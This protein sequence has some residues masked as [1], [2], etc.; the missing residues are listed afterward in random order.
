[1]DEVHIAQV[2]EQYREKHK[3]DKFFK[4]IEGGTTGG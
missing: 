3:D 2:H 1:M 4:E